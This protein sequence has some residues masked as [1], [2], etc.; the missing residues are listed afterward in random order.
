M[1]WAPENNPKGAMLYKNLKNEFQVAAT[2]PGNE[3]GLEQ[4]AYAVSTRPTITVYDLHKPR[5]SAVNILSPLNGS[6]APRASCEIRW[7]FT[8]ADSTDRQKA[9]RLQMERR[10]DDTAVIE[11]ESLL[12]QARSRAKWEQQSDVR[13]CRGDGLLLGS[14]INP[15]PFEGSLNVEKAGDYFCW[16]RFRWQRDT[17]T[18]ITIGDTSNALI[19]NGQERWQWGLLGRFPLSAGENEITIEQ[20]GARPDLLDSFILSADPSFNPDKDPLWV[21]VV[22]TGEVASP[23][24]YVPLS[25]LGALE[26]GTYRARVLAESEKGCRGRWSPYVEFTLSGTAE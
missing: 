11:A 20:T 1:H 22:D 14:S 19:G 18:K 9:Y 16:V 2:F 21:P 15:P 6:F 23:E 8:D 24:T 26:S 4:C 10:R 25:R 13:E 3:L 17:T 5:C 12:A 7:S